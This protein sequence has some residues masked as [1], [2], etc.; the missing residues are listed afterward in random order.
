MEDDVYFRDL[1]WNA[2][3]Y[4]S[5]ANGWVSQW[6]LLFVGLFL[7]HVCFMTKCLS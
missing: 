3:P 2:Q 5:R 4:I 7:I 1:M 6:A